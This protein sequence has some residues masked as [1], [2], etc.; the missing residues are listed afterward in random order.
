MKLKDILSRAASAVLTVPYAVI[1]QTSPA[2]A[3]ESQ[4]GNIKPTKKAYSTLVR[5][6]NN[7]LT[8]D[9]SLSA[10]DPIPTPLIDYLFANPNPKGDR[11]PKCG[12]DEITVS[13]ANYCAPSSEI[14][15]ILSKLNKQPYNDH[16]ATQAIA[17]LNIYSAYIVARQVANHATS[18]LNFGFEDS[19]RQSFLHDCFSGEL[20]RSVY[21]PSGDL[22]QVAE[23]VGDDMSRFMNLGLE[24]HSGG[25]PNLAAIKRAAFQFGFNPSNSC[26]DYKPPVTT[27]YAFN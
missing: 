4:P 27:G 7:Y 6:F 25:D 14:F 13:E 18:T 1:L 15:F 2:I 12:D 23:T 3:G 26:L 21:N 9:G 16:F 19:E 17:G 20:L 24:K 10:Y 5:Q 8:Y 11:T 22:T